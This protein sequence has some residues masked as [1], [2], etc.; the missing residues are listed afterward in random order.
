MDGVIMIVSLVVV[1]CPV[2]YVVHRVLKK[3]F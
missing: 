3:F 2:A 1:V